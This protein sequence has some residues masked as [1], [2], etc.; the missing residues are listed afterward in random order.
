[1]TVIVDKHGGTLDKYIGD[2]VMVFF[3][4]PGKSEPE[5]NAENCLNMGN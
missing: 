4:A 2:A 3:G 1:M 5:D